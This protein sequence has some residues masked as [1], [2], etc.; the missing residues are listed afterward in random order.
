M[1]LHTP[2]ASHV[3]KLVSLSTAGL[4]VRADSRC[5]GGPPSSL[6]RLGVVMSGQHPAQPRARSGYRKDMAMCTIKGLKYPS[7]NPL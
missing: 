5:R 6:K 7:L 1:R 2:S 4:G 3:R